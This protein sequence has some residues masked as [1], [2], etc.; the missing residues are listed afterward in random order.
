[1]AVDR[2]YKFHSVYY[3]VAY[4]SQ[5]NETCPVD[6][7]P[8]HPIRWTR[9]EWSGDRKKNE[10]S[11]EIRKIR[12][13]EVLRKVGAAF[14]KYS[15]KANMQTTFAMFKPRDQRFAITIWIHHYTQ[16][17][18]EAYF[19]RRRR[20]KRN[21]ASGLKIVLAM[22]KLRRFNLLGYPS[23]SPN[24]RPSQFFP[25]LTR[26]HLFKAEYPS[27]FWGSSSFKEYWSYAR[28]SVLK[29]RKIT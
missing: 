13:A 25:L 28:P 3:S 16:E 27:R 18:R 17:K 1:M 4:P 5:P 22:I 21:G 24:L 7:L 6:L 15:S 14:A 23:L 19:T 9:M 26:R 20:K 2:R 29:S 12:D 11:Y 8:L 10:I